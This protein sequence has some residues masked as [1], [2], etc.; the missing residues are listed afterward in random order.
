MKNS[1]LS[2]IV[3][4]LLAQDSRRDFVRLAVGE[5]V[6]DETQLQT[7]WDDL[8][9]QTPLSETKLNLRI[10]PAEQQCMWCFFVY[11]PAKGE[12][13][14]PQCRS[15]GAKIVHGEEFFLEEE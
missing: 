6:F 14:C 11:R 5:L 1:R 12:T 15:V 2:T 7:E 9:K 3:R 13:R 10:I 8:T 4:N